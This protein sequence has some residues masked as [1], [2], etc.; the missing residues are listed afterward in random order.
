MQCL[1]IL[2]NVI[3]LQVLEHGKVSINGRQ[4]LVVADD[5]LNLLGVGNVVVRYLLQNDASISILGNTKTSN[6]FI[7]HYALSRFQI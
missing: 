3:L 4:S 6:P 5:I 1:G 7:I 2:H